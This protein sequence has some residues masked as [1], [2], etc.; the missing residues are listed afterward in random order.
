MI[1]KSK[2]LRKLIFLK[3]YLILYIFFI[4]LD[5]KSMEGF[6]NNFNAST[7]SFN[8]RE[9]DIANLNAV[10]QERYDVAKQTGAEQFS[11][12]KQTQSALDAATKGRAGI[13]EGF[14]GVG[15]EPL[16]KSSVDYASKSLYSAGKAAKASRLGTRSQAMAEGQEV[17]GENEGRGFTELASDGMD[18]ELAQHAASVIKAPGQLVS[19]AVDAG[20]SI[21]KSI[22]R[23]V[24]G[25]PNKGD[26]PEQ[27][28]ELKNVEP[29]ASEASASEPSS[30]PSSQ[31]M[32]SGTSSTTEDLPLQGGQRSGG[33]ATETTELSSAGKGAQEQSD[34]LVSTAGK[35]VGKGGAGEAEAGASSAEAG[36]GAGEAG[37]EAGAV[38]G[39]VGA[40]VAVD[41]G[42]AAADAA[43]IASEAVPGIG[44]V[45]GGVIALGAG[46]ASIF[47]G[48]HKAP[49][50]KPIPAPPP[51]P[52]LSGA[53][54]SE[55]APVMDS[56]IFRATGY[57]QLA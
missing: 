50:P 7:S 53:S 51:P 15:A 46:I 31:P 37:A 27:G 38:A 13:E 16:L 2:L 12:A 41:A 30:L 20:K 26:P 45:V 8:R 52:K 22:Y 17:G 55:A 9:S 14:A 4:T 29:S 40:D 33:Q 48:Q 18:S 47:E 36:A 39:E 28:T 23:G 10:G 42:I 35:E 54:I 49:K 34:T 43:A 5:Y 44:T 32:S 57:N 1:E 6:M 56:S 11:A 19:K 3:D 25:G 24:A 21:G